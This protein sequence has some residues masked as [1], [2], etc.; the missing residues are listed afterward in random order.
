MMRTI[1]F[2]PTNAF[3]WLDEY[4]WRPLRLDV[5]K[6]VPMTRPKS[7]NLSEPITITDDL[8]RAFSTGA[9]RI[10][11]DLRWM[12]RWGSD[13]IVRLFR[14]WTGFEIFRLHVGLRDGVTTVSGVEV[15]T[16][17]E[18]HD[19]TPKQAEDLLRKTL[20][21]A[22]EMPG[23]VDGWPKDR[24][25][26]LTILLPKRDRVSATEA[27]RRVQEVLPRRVTRL[28]LMVEGPNAAAN[29]WLTHA[30][31][32]F[33]CMRLRFSEGSVLW[34]VDPLRVSVSESGVQTEHTGALFWPA[35]GSQLGIGSPAW[36]VSRFPDQTVV[37]NIDFDN[38]IVLPEGPMTD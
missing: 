24:D 19:N 15:E 3:A 9:G 32:D 11:M 23:Y 2:N 34:L 25:E 26:A 14:S 13:D 1:D 37:S 21:V 27:A 12:W 6:P 5:D 38:A 18:R 22:R 8:H 35:P 4:S 10:D 36:A 17:Q 30:E 7:M 31:P 33:E 16:D 20:N 28:Q 29:A